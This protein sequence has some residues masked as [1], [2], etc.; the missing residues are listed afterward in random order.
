MMWKLGSIL[1]IAVFYTVYLGKMIRQRKQGIRTDHMGKGKKDKSLVRTELIMKTVTYGIVAVQLVSIGSGWSLLPFGF[2]VGGILLGTAGV[3]LFT[4]AILTMQESW[5]AGIPDDEKT[6]MITGGIYQ[7]SR[8]PAFLGFYL[9]YAGILLLYFNWLLLI[10]TILAV[11]ML[12]LQILQEERYL[13]TVFGVEYQE[14][15]QRVRR[16]F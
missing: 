4:A 3:I 5:R 13:P 14:Y 2:R 15:K 10:V 12:H 6:R 11:G 7:Y 16:Y 1:I 8:N 9:M